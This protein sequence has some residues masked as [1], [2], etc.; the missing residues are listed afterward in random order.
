[1]KDQRP[2]PDALLEVATDESHRSKR[3]QLKIFFGACAGVGKTFAM[4]NAARQ[5]QADGVPVGIGIVETHGRKDTEELIQGLPVLPRKTMS[6]NGKPTTEFDLDGALSSGYKLLVVDELAH[7]NVAGSRHAKRWQDVEELL[8]AGIDVFTALNV[9]HLDSLNDIV[10]GII[11]IRVRETVPDRIFDAATDVVLVDLP[12]DDLLARMNAGKVYLPVSIE[13]ARQNFFRRGNLIALRELALRRVADRVNS[14]V[15]TYRVSHAIRTVWPTQDLLMVCVRADRSQEKLVRE[16]TRLAQRLQAKWIVVHVDQP[17]R[18]DDAQA[19][20]SLLE[21]AAAAQAAGAEFANIPGQDVAETLLD[22]ARKRNA[23]KLI[24]GNPAGRQFIPFKPRLQERIARANPEVGLIILSVDAAPEAHQSTM[25]DEPQGYAR[26]LAIATL[27][28]GVTTAAAAWLLRVF[29]LSN[30]V[31]LFL[32]T[33]VFVAMRLGRLAGAWAALLC[34]ACFDFF[35]VEPRLSFAV[36]DTQYV[37][38]FALMLVVALVISQLAA[39][40]RSE[41]RFARAGERRAS[42]LARVARELSSAIKVEQVITVC[43]DAISPLFGARIILLVPDDRDRLLPM[44]DAALVDL[45]VAQWAFDHSQEA[46]RGTQ[47]LA[48]AEALYLPL[49]ASMATR[50]VLCILPIDTPLSSNPDDRRLLDACCST[51]GLALERI[52]FVEVAQDTLVRMEGEKLRN[53][54]LSAVSHDLKTPLTAIRGLAETLEHGKG[55]P[56]DE[57]SDLARSIRV[58]ADELKRLVSNL[59]DLA[60]MQSQGVRLNKEWHSLSEIVGSALAQSASLL[61]PRSI[62]TN[63]PPELPLVEVDA[64]LIER[65]LINLFDNAAKYTPTSAAITVR[66]GTSGESI[67]LVVEDDGPG[68]TAGD[69]EALFE[70]FVR[71]Q[72]ESATAGV[73]LGLALCRSIILAHGGT[74]RAEARKPHGATFEIRLPLGAPPEIESEIVHDQ[75]AH[76]DR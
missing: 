70:P 57:R 23:T 9:Q 29:D 44:Q 1:M 74:I 3:G 51:I 36:T 13:R 28:C 59:L 72:K 75:A 46:G 14:D 30:I 63:L 37:F 60:R 56:E 18:G 19:R 27:A 20:G 33:V 25:A 49:K 17:Y 61:A 48:A 42:A 21:I 34:V 11:G 53:A 35:F 2:D 54:L 22:Y 26:A 76:P 55:L 24:L 50:G 12:P 6:G 64:A 4:L 10:G 73:G 41:A 5:L 52:H 31:M 67:Y 38:T 15:R 62:R 65:V 45:S 40:M 66:A 69:P 39:R 47:T 43:R 71:G 32:M 7:T 68:W 58:Q 8:D 16:G